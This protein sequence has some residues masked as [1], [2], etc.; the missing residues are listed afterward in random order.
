MEL[1]GGGKKKNNV[2]PTRRTELNITEASASSIR[3]LPLG[4]ESMQQMSSKAGENMDS[5][6]YPERPGEPD[7]PYY[8]NS[9][10]CRF[11]MHC[12]FNH[13]PVRELHYLET[14]KC[15]FG[16]ACKFHHPKY[17]PGIIRTV[18]FNVLGYPLRPYEVDCKFYLSNGWCKFSKTCKFNHP[19]PSNS[20]PWWLS[21]TT[22]SQT[23]C[24]GELTSFNA[25]PHWQGPSSYAQV[26]LP[27]GLDQVP[28]W[29][30]FPQQ[31]SGNGQFV[32]SGAAMGPS[33]S[34]SSFPVRPGEPDCPFFAK[35]GS[36]KFGL[37]CRFNHPIGKITLTSDCELSPVGLPLRPGE[38]KCIFYGRYGFCGYGSTCKFDHPIASPKGITD[39]LSTSSSDVPVVQQPLE[40]ASGPATLTLSSESS[41]VGSPGKLKRIPSTKPQK[42]NSAENL[43]SLLVLF[44]KKKKENSRERER[45]RVSKK[46]EKKIDQWLRSYVAVNLVAHKMKMPLYI[47]ILAMALEGYE[48]CVAIFRRVLESLDMFCVCD[49]IIGL[50]LSVAS[51]L[52]F[53]KNSSPKELKDNNGKNTNTTK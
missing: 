53:F 22:P 20:M 10:D 35:T 24:P 23:L 17:I 13:P 26:I 6:S 1:N 46:R 4:E 51:T 40:S 41:P 31:N 29:N 18:Q 39:S 11:G 38:P 37:G 28:S 47:R 45:E 9:G 49:L 44:F 42:M 19:E 25:S 32:G 21:R 33:A 27:Q 52:L 12:R 5:I 2:E 3:E 7:C 15:N 8:L 36:C 16:P 43:S 48:R 50:Y 30:T 14:G 34:Y